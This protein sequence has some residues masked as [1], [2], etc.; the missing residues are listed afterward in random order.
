MKGSIFQIN[1]SNG[2]VPKTPIDDA[3]VN[4]LGITRDRQ[5]DLRHH[6]SPDQALCLFAVERLAVLAS[7]GHHVAPGF[8]G[9]NIT[10]IDIDWDLIVPGRQLLLGDEVLVEVT[11]YASPCQ[12]NARWF[13]G[14]DFS[15]IDQA[16]HPGFSRVYARV[17]AGGAIHTGDAV[18]IADEESAADRLLRKQPHTYR[19]PRDFA[20]V[21]NG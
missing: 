4:N 5:A 1:V 6:G 10:L 19:W 13:K 12:K 17:L 15:R 16:R 9:E 18:T 2:G 20:G 7:E 3:V 11:D 14:G 8:T 21:A